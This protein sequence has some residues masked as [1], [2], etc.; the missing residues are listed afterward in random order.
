MN[1]FWMACVVIGVGVLTVAGCGETSGENAAPL[2]GFVC[3]ED[4]STY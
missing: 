2:E 3:G 4:G 1:R